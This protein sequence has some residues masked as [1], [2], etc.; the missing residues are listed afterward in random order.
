MDT[1]SMVGLTLTSGNIVK[2]FPDTNKHFAR[3]EP[4]TALGLVKLVSRTD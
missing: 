4:R 1:L 2:V 3:L